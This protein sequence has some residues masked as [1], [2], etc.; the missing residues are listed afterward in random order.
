MMLK[1]KQRRLRDQHE[2]REARGVL[3]TVAALQSDVGSLSRPLAACGFGMTLLRSG[4]PSQTKAS[5][6]RFVSNPRW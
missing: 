3:G 6:T 5:N 1:R 2:R 4:Y